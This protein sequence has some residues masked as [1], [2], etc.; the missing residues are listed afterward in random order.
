MLLGFFWGDYNYLHSIP[1]GEK[2]PGIYYKSNKKN[3]W[4]IISKL[5]TLLF[6]SLNRRFHPIS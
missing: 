4:R 1:T 5:W 6:E 2:N 3:I